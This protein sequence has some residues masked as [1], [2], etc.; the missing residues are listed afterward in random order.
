MDTQFDH[1]DDV[2][3]ECDDGNE[4]FCN[5]EEI[6]QPLYP[7][8]NI[9]ICGAYCAIMHLKSKCNLPFS[10]VFELLKLLQF[11]CPQNNRLPTSVY[12][13]RKFFCQWKS[14]KKKTVFCSNC[15]EQVI[16]EKC[17][18]SDCLKP[19]NSEPDILIEMDLKKQFKTILSS[20]FKILM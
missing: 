14:H 2:N 18:N 4:P 17:C 7:G 16:S 3:M 5:I 11:I 13:L 9:T 15:H 12:L 1:S 20:K 19:G 8:A 10:T 6:F